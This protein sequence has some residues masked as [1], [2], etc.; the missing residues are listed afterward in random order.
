MFINGSNLWRGGKKASAKTLVD[1]DIDPRYRIDFEKLVALTTKGHNRLGAYFY[2]LELLPRARKRLRR[3]RP[4]PVLTAAEKNGFKIQLF[5]HSKASHDINVAMATDIRNTIHG[6]NAPEKENIVFIVVTINSDLC[7]QIATALS[8]I[9]VELWSW[10]S[11]AHEFRQLALLASNRFTVNTL[12]SHLDAFSYTEYI[13][14]DRSID[15]THSNAIVYRNVPESEYFES[16]LAKYLQQLNLLFYIIPAGSQKDLIVEFPKTKFDALQK[17]RT[18]GKF[19]Y[20]PC[21]YLEY[22]RYQHNSKQSSEPIQLT[23]RFEAL[24]EFTEGDEPKGKGE[25]QTVLGSNPGN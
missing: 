14:N 15:P 11:T 4:P 17:L 12:D 18:L 13:H 20:Q 23:N 8:N 5:E 9:P 1:A 2:G 21:S 10:E 7:Q 3:S 22:Y 19:P 16:E 24:G 6:L 25:L